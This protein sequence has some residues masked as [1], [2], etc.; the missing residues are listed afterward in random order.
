[1]S[2]DRC[3]STQLQREHVL[4]EVDA[5]AFAV[6]EQCDIRLRLKFS[7]KLLANRR[8]V[9]RAFTHQEQIFDACG[10]EHLSDMSRH[11]LQ[12]QSYF[13]AEALKLKGIGIGAMLGN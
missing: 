9:K 10:I 6:Q 4:I 3:A 13:P 11:A 5:L 1:M 2:I 8:R 7:R 12:G